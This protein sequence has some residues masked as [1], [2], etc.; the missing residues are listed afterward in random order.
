MQ[1]DL[2]V[3]LIIAHKGQLTRFEE[4]SLEQCF[5]VLKRYPI[6][7]VCPRGLDLGAYQRIVPDIQADF[8]DPEWL[9]SYQRFARLKIEPFLYQR[10]KK[11]KFVFF[12]ELDAFV[13]RDE[14]EYWCDK[15]FDYIGAPWIGA[16]W[17]QEFPLL[18][19]E[20][21]SPVGNGGFSLRRSKALLKALYSFSLVHRPE[22]LRED[23]KGRPFT[24]R[25]RYLFAN[26]TVKNNS[27]Y[28]FNTF[29]RED[30]FWGIYM[31]RNFKWF[32]VAP[33]EEAIKFS[34]E[35]TPREL[36]EENGRNLPFGCHAWW[37]YDLDFWRPFIQKEGYLI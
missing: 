8:I 19:K 5:K 31:S 11:Y 21:I 2:V 20:K 9:A 34:L 28:L 17:F 6:R 1:E 12:Y 24:A 25:A 14:L 35:T 4:I 36:Y 33:L 18:K 7:L 37:K 22:E 27:F 16:P 3:I 30:V 13:F 32:K 26:M 10:Y 23:V 29:T 15:G